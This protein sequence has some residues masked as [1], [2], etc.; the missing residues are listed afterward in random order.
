MGLSASTDAVLPALT[1]QFGPAE[2]ATLFQ[3]RCLLLLKQQE[4]VALVSKLNVTTLAD[5]KVISPGDLGVL[6]FGD[7]DSPELDAAVRLLYRTFNVLRK[8]PFLDAADGGAAMSIGDLVVAATFHSGRYKRLLPETNYTKLVFVTLALTATDLEKKEQEPGAISAHLKFPVEETDGPEIVASKIIWK[9]LECTNIDN[10]QLDLT[11]AAADLHQL[12]T[13][14][15]VILAPKKNQRDTKLDLDHDVTIWKEFE[16]SA[17]SLLRYFDVTITPAKLKTSQLTY[18][19]F[20]RGLDAVP[21]LLQSSFT[22]I[23]RKIFSPNIEVE[24]RDE[25]PRKKHKFQDTKLVNHATIALISSVLNPR[26]ETPITTS[27]VVK[28]YAGSEAGFSIRSLEL[29][30]F[31][32]QAP[33]LLIVSGKRLKS[34]TI[35][36]NKRYEQFNSEYPRF[37]RPSDDHIRDWQSDNDKLTYVVAVNQ[38]WRNS[39][40]KNF[41]DEKSAVLQVLP[42]LDYYESIHSSVLKGELTYFNTLGLGLGFGNSQPIKKNGMAKYFPGDIS[43]TIE[44]NLEFAVFRHLVDLK[45]NATTYFKNSKQSQVLNL[46]FEDRF[47]ITDLEVWG[48]GSTKELDEQKKQWEWEEKQAQARQSVNIKS[49]GEERAFLEMAGLIGNHNT[50]GG[51]V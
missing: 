12:L 9:A 28:L 33:T 15:L 6:L 2:L 7:V 50:S 26:S 39:N 25:A 5:A 49:M 17:M 19:Q 42:R 44:A 41:G 8:F 30:I 3:Q 37:F 35:T 18:T 29:K 38:P 46:D 16:A 36:T 11:V 20:E 22:N 43:L 21:D 45:T 23:I 13:L 1:C 32:W 27:N 34:K 14:F 47:M 4:A 10:Y 40:K 51:S 24:P 48:V 31:K